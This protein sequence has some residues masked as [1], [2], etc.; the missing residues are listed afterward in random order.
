MIRILYD[1][2]MVCYMYTYVHSKGTWEG[3]WGEYVPRAC[4]ASE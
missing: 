3:K 4:K 1:L 2:D